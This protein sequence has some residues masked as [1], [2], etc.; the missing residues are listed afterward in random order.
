MTVPEHAGWF[1][2]VRRIIDIA[3]VTPGLPIPHI[4]SDR[5]TYFYTGITHPTEALQAVR[6][7]ETILRSAFLVAF[8]PRHTIAHDVRHDILT[9]V[10]PSGL[11]VDLVTLARH[12]GVQDT[13]VSQ[14]EAAEAA[15]ERMADLR[16]AVAAA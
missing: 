8:Y 7:A 11:M 13:P 16:K 10:L 14:P 4:S 6:E 3:E 1:D 5:V 2:D 12:S 9:A 15:A